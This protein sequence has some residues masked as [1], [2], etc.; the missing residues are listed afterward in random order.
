MSE[1]DK[2]ILR[3]GATPRVDRTKRS[4]TDGSPV[5]EDGSHT[6]DRGD[7]QQRGYVV[8]TEDERRRGY[9]RPVRNKYVHQKCGTVTVM[10]MALAQTYARDPK[11]YSGTYCVACGNHFPVGPEGEFTWDG[12]TEKVGT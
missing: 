10:G 1:V 5:P 12:T 4:L 3:A 7:G 2:I 9:V 11:F 8:L 6:E